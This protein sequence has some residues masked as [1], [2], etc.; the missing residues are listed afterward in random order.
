M[1]AEICAEMRAEWGVRCGECARVRDGVEEYGVVIVL[2]VYLKDWACSIY[3]TG[4]PFY[5][6]RTCV[7]LYCRISN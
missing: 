5:S 2:L 3:R 7:L 1:E 4:S 6:I